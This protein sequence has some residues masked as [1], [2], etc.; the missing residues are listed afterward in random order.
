M[1]YPI[2]FDFEYDSVRYAERKGIRVTKQLI[3][4]MT[5]AFCR[6]VKEAGYIPMVYTN[7]DYAR[8][9]F[10]VTQLRKEGDAIWYA[11]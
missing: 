10:D 8:I 6:E 7:K 3:M 9:Y 11:Y 5:V 4:E 1:A 2:A